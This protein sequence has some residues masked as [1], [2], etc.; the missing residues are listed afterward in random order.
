M[1]VFLDFSFRHIIFFVLITCILSS[2]S[3]VAGPAVIA[4]VDQQLWHEPISTNEGFNKASRAAQLIYVRN[5]KAM[6]LQSDDEIMSFSKI[7]SV[8]RNSVDQWISKELNFSFGNYVQAAKDCVQTD[9]TCVLDV[10]SLQQLQSQADAWFLTV[11]KSH[12]P[13]RENIDNFTR[14]YIAEQIRLAAL[15]PKV[16]SEINTFNEYEWDGSALADMQFYLTFDDGPTAQNGSTDKTLAML[17]AQKKSAAFFVVGD[18]L[19]KRINATDSA[20]TKALYANQ[21]VA[22]HG[23]KHVSHAEWDQWQDSVTK[24]KNLVAGLIDENNVLPLFRPPYGLRTADSGD[25]IHTQQ[26]KVALWNIDSQDWIEGVDVD[27]V[28][29][30]VIALA[31]IKRHGV[32]L[33][34]DFYPKASVAL[35]IVFSQLGNAI[36]WNDCHSLEKL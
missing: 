24:T 15:F 34:H 10:K 21:C 35:P 30:R 18:N 6:Q 16:S 11:P 8:N 26:L 28:A 5:L 25:F 14:V 31:L 33:F 1:R 12:Q 27:T 13:W 9:W 23:W 2:Q 32:I 3:A 36:T 20:S 7:K 4:M 29:N 22:L 19:Q 17:K